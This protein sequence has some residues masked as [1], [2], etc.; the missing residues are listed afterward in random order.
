M[1]DTNNNAL[2]SFILGINNGMAQMSLKYAN[3][4]LG[5][6]PNLYRLVKEEGCTSQD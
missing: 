6:K 2:P 1:E 4:I 3:H 5:S